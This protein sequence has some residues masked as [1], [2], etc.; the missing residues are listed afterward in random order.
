M[1]IALT[2]FILALLSFSC[3]RN[4][5]EAGNRQEVLA[6]DSSGSGLPEQV[7][8]TDPL[9]KKILSVPDTLYEGD[10]L[11]INFKTPHPRDF[12]IVAPDGHFFYVVHS[13]NDTLMPSLMDPEEFERTTVLE[14]ITDKTKVSPY[15]VA[16]NHNTLLFT[17]T[18]RYELRL[19]EQLCTDDGTPMET[20]TVFYLDRP[21]KR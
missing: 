21:R 5:G 18:G 6:V 12:A 7:Y 13:Q 19:S 4:N 3:V 16:I 10:T 8:V 2:A 17:R 15:D 14:I 1:R 11:R 20:E 9:Q